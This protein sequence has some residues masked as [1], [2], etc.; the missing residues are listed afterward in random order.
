[1]NSSASHFSFDISLYRVLLTYRNS[2]VMDLVFLSELLTVVC[3]VNHSVIIINAQHV[4]IMLARLHIS[5]YS[6]MFTNCVLFMTFADQR[7][8]FVI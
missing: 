8:L 1:M 5:L 4:C 2:A 7:A 6:S 3:N